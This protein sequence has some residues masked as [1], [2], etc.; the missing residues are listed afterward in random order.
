LRYFPEGRRFTRKGVERD[1]SSKRVSGSGTPARPARATRWMIAL[2][3]PPIAMSLL[4]ALSKALAVR[5]SEGRGPPPCA[6]STARRP[7]SSARARRRESGAGIAALPGRVMPRASAIE[8]IVDAVPMTMQWPDE[9]E[10]HASTSQS[11][12]SVRRSA[13]RSAHRRRTSVPE[14]SSSARHLPR[15]IGP[16][17]TMMAGTSAEAAPIS[18][19]GVVL[20]QPESRTT[21]S[22]GY[23]RMHSSTS[24]AMRLRNSIVVGF[25]RTS[26]SEIVGNSSGNPPAD[27]TPRFTAS[28]TWRRW[29]LQLVSSDHEFA[30]PMTGRPSNI[31][32]LKPSVFSHERAAKPSRSMR[33]N[34]LRLRKVCVVMCPSETP[35]IST[36]ECM[37]R[38][39]GK[40]AIV[41][42]GGSGIG[43]GIVLAMA[44]EGADIAIP[45]IQVLN[46][47]KAAD[48]VKA[49]GRRVLAMKCDVTST[50]DVKLMVDRTRDVLGRIDVL[51]NNAGIASPPGMPFTNNTE[52]DWDRAFAVNTKS[53]F[54]TSKAVAPYFLERKAGRIINIA[55]IAGPLSAVTMPAYSVAKQGVITFTRVVAKE[56]APHRI[57]VNAICPGVLY[58]DFW[59][60]LAQHI[61]DTNPAFKGMTARQVFEKRVADIVPMKCEQTPEDIGNAAVFLASDEARY[62]T[63]Q[64]LMVDGGCVMW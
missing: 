16:P 33:P 10:R 11:S 37:A 29:A 8:A 45:D 30:M 32:S 13:R 18:M 40:V 39:E 63:G 47:E 4:I 56:L 49:L 41:T 43:R 1:S 9:R 15:S 62:I 53:V 7:L 44:K 34:Q 23:A 21:E 24:M 3:E 19:A 17:V 28:A 25:M 35:I 51:V 60:K 50:S 54:L 12:S 27:S 48:E 22:S 42:G 64:A 38:L 31:R 20:S 57:T 55:S 6:S 5:I 2:V 36:E 14:P 46:A 58:T 52:D 59:Q 61:A 26:P